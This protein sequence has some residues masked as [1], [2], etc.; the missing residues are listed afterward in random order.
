MGHCWVEAVTQVENWPTSVRVDALL[1]YRQQFRSP[2]APAIH[3]SLSALRNILPISTVQ[4]PPMK[5]ALART[6]V[7]CWL[8][9]KAQASR[10]PISPMTFV[11]PLWSA[12]L[13]H[14]CETVT[15]IHL[16]ISP[17][18]GALTRATRCGSEK[19]AF[20]YVRSRKSRAVMRKKNLQRRRSGRSR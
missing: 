19:G 6:F 11:C 5:A 1:I 12:K 2:I 17:C 3:L 13:G 4:E 16:P 15:G 20:T 8:Q 9:G 7:A 14:D 18:S 10:L